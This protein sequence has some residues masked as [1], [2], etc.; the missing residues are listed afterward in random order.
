M[1]VSKC[2]IIIN[3][4]GNVTGDEPATMVCK[5]SAAA[6][7]NINIL[8]RMF[9]FAQSGNWDEYM[10]RQEILFFQNVIPLLHTE[11]NWELTGN[12]AKLP[13]YSH[14]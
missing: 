9:V 5:I 14:I 1:I 3:Y 6:P 11:R 7:R 2:K 13:Q 10:C 4:S 8:W 12:R